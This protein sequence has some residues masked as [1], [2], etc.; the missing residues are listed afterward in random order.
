MPTINVLSKVTTL[1][2]TAQNTFLM[3]FPC[4]ELLL[5]VSNNF[6]IINTYQT[7]WYKLK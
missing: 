7:N 1:P 2:N 3:I 5:N 4:V 6:A